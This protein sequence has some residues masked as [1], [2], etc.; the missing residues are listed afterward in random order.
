MKIKKI[1]LNKFNYIFNI[2]KILYS[3]ILKSP[4]ICNNFSTYEMKIIL[5]YGNSI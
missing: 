5:K 3:I 2:N 4:Y 1:S